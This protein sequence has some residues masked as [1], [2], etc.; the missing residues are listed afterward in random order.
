MKALVELRVDRLS[1]GFESQ[2]SIQVQKD[3][4]RKTN[5]NFP[6]DENGLGSSPSALTDLLERM[7]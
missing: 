4:F 1:F 5:L 2:H 6:F 3:Q 7:V